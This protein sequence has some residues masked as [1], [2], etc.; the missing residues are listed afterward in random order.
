VPRSRQS[1]GWC[2]RS[3]TPRGR[4]RRG[5]VTSRRMARPPSSSAR[6]RKRS[7][8]RAP[9][10][11]SRPTPDRRGAVAMP[12]PLLAP[13]TT[14]VPGLIMQI[15]PGGHGRDDFAALIEVL[16][17]AAGTRLHAPDEKEP[18]ASAPRMRPLE[19]VRTFRFAARFSGQAGPEVF[20]QP[21]SFGKRARS[22]EPLRAGTCSCPAAA[23][24]RNRQ[25]LLPDVRSS[26]GTGRRS[27]AKRHGAGAQP[28][29][30]ALQ[31]AW[32]RAKTRSR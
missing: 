12:I 32:R 13:V 8:R 28:R 19:N 7:S 23:R 30:A 17:A 1:R 4:E 29:P 27:P 22:V 18:S 14:A 5:S 26:L 21:R 15:D 25:R 16:Y 24:R 9:T 11:T 6:A 20:P 2:H 3:R 10:T 31:A